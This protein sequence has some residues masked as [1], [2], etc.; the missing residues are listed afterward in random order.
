MRIVSLLPGATEI[1]CALGLRDQLIAVSHECDYP[2]SVQNLPRLSSTQLASE[3][4]AVAIDKLVSQAQANGEQL[5]RLDEPLLRQLQPDLVVS[6]SLCGVCAID[7]S[8]VQRA[9]TASDTIPDIVSLSGSDFEGILDDIR[10]IG[11]ATSCVTQADDLCAALTRRWRAAQSPLKHDVPAVLFVEWSQPGYYAGHWVP[12]M[13]ERAGGRDIFG[14]TGDHSG[15]F[16]WTQALDKKPDVIV[17]GC[18]GFDLLR[19]QALAEE[20]A[21]TAIGQEMV[22]NASGGLWAVDADGFFSRP[23][24]RVVDGMLA[25]AELLKGV[26]VKGVSV[27]VAVVATA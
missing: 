1:L 3:L 25:L 21:A 26:P 27:K 7:A 14:R 5:N 2:A 16:E 13:I 8:A 6:Q 19:N 22:A 12:Q 4:N 23:G 17:F 9:L 11:Q 24:P 15:V 10:Q 20:F 18:C